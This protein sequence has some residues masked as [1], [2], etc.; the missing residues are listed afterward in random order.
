MSHLST[1]LSLHLLLHSCPLFPY[2]HFISSLPLHPLCT[3][4]DSCPIFLF[5]HTLLTY[6][7][8]PFSLHTSIFFAF[9]PLLT[10]SPLPLQSTTPNLFSL[11]LSL[12]FIPTSF[13]HLHIHFPSLN[14]LPKA[15]STHYH[16]PL[17]T[18]T[19]LLPPLTPYTHPPLFSLTH[20]QSHLHLHSLCS[21]LLSA[22][23]LS[24]IFT[25]LYPSSLLIHSLLT[26]LLHSP[27]HTQLFS[28]SFNPLLT[29]LLNIYKTI[30]PSTSV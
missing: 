24:P 10:P 2:P 4:P 12:F 16:L 7:S 5:T 18:S 19:Y 21:S 27:F 29:H 13:T 30:S 15:L 6:S 22:P 17:S 9:F 20:F 25:L 23:P 3:L 14:C 1:D 26:S 8:T 28:L 11:H